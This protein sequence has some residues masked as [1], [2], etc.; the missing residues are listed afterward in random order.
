MTDKTNDWANEIARDLTDNWTYSHG[1]DSSKIAAALRKAKA[2]G[3]RE[4][5][6]RMDGMLSL[7]YFTDELS[8]LY[9][10]ADKIERN[11]A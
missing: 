10:L 2:D 6:K 4:A 9:S 11:D 1:V 8:K 3:M 5:A 7:V